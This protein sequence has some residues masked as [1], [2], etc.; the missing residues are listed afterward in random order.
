M[1]INWQDDQNAAYLC[2][3]QIMIQLKTL[4]G[5]EGARLL[6][7]KL[8]LGKPRWNLRRGNFPTAR[9]KRMPAAESNPA[10]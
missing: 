10:G 9:G 8:A 1:E 4:I 5:A 2:T 3:L 7:D 6:R